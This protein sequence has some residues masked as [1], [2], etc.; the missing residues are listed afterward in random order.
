MAC[1][2]RYSGG[3]NG[4]CGE[5]CNGSGNGSNKPTTGAKVTSEKYATSKKG[6]MGS[7]HYIQPVFT[8]ISNTK[9]T[10]M[11]EASGYIFRLFIGSIL[12]EIVLQAS[13]P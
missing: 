3:N 2:Y 8:I 10:N 11:K 7:Q 4:G 5:C 9:L 1:L 13:T 12:G 6:K